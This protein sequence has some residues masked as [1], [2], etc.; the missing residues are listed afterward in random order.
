MDI[1]TQYNYEKKWM[2]TSSK[3]ALRMIEEEMPQTD[4]QGILDYI[5][6]ELKQGKKVTLGTCRFMSKE[7]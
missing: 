1:Y 3:D 2:K 5:I 6:S 4:A 7:A